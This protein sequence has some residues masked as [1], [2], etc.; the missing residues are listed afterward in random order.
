MKQ[1]RDLTNRNRIRGIRGRTSGRLVA[2]STSIKDH[3]CRSGRAAVTAAR[4]TP[5]DLRS[6]PCTG[7]RES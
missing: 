4:L 7:L 6:V 3:G 2:K 1:S 5:G